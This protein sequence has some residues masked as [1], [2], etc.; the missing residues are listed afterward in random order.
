M[1]GS[2][3]RAEALATLAHSHTFFY[4]SSAPPDLVLED[5][6]EDLESGEPALAGTRA[7]DPTQLLDCRYLHEGATLTRLAASA[8]LQAGARSTVTCQFRA[9]LPCFA[10]AQQSSGGQP[11]ALHVCVT[12]PGLPA[13][14]GYAAAVLANV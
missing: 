10:A 1:P 14:V 4:G 12:R 7:L 5:G 3:Y 9:D 6:S 2:A 13:S 8:I 11:C